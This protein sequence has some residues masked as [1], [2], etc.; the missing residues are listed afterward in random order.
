MHFLHRATLL[1]AL[2][3]LLGSA[4]A[5]PPA[6]NEG[7]LQQQLQQAVW[8][9]DIVDL[10]TQYLVRF[11]SGSA[12]GQA[13]TLRDQAGATMRV[14]SARDV[15]LYRNAFVEAGDGA[16][17]QAELRRAALGD[18]Q[19]AVRLARLHQ[20]GEGGVARDENRYLGWLQLAAMLGDD[21]ASY[22]LALHYRREAQPVL[23]AQY[24]AR[25]VE[26]GF[27]PPR[28]LDHIRK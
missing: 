12:A 3:T 13:R 6:E 4:F 21:R 17:L 2:S 8:P 27:T 19:A 24:E 9:G 28:D 11:P 18:R 16:S 1:F 15:R 5:A 25:A 10:A 22:E 14:L 23:A 26:L 7:K 20:R